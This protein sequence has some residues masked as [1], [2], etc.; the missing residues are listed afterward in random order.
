LY[1]ALSGPL[2]TNH[3]SLA[4]K[5]PAFKAT[6]R[7]VIISDCCHSGGWCKE[8]KQMISEPTR[9]KSSELVVTVQ[10]SCKVYQESYYDDHGSL[11]AKKLIRDALCSDSK[12]RVFWASAD[13]F[14]CLATT[15]D[16]KSL[17]VTQLE[18]S[19]RQISI[20]GL[21]LKPFVK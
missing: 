2:A 9:G 4:Q 15:E 6:K 5:S 1:G 19:S 21:V 3:A 20:Y 17:Q 14:P 13:Q 11:L 10:S 16:H 18:G 7:L 12:Q 8:L